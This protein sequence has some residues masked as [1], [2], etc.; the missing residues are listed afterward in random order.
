MNISKII[1][2]GP[3]SFIHI[4][5]NDKEI[6]LF[7]DEHIDYKKS[8]YDVLNFIKIIAD[9]TLEQKKCIDFFL[10]SPF[11]NIHTKQKV[12]YDDEIYNDPPL[13]TT[14]RNEF[15]VISNYHSKYDFFRIHYW[16]LSQFGIDIYISLIINIE[17]YIKVNP[18]YDT[19]TIYDFYCNNDESK[20]DKL[21]IQL[22]DKLNK[23]KSKP[24]YFFYDEEKKM[25]KII[26]K[27][28]NNIDD[29]FFNK[30]TL[31][32]YF[33]MRAS[34]ED[35]RFPVRLSILE[36][37]SIARIFRKKFKN[38]E[39]EE[40][41]TFGNKCDAQNINNVIYF[42]G[43]YHVLNIYSFLKSLKNECIIINYEY[44][45]NSSIQNNEI[46]FPLLNYFNLFDDSD[47][48]D[49]PLLEESCNEPELKRLF[50]H[51]IPRKQK[52]SD[53][54]VRTLDNTYYISYYDKVIKMTSEEYKN[55]T[56]KIVIPEDYNTNNTNKF[57]YLKYLKYKFKYLKLKIKD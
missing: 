37:Y 12:K 25:S 15:S 27:Q 53:S 2:T 57:T 4:K 36:T 38:R 8:P 3:I 18:I 35:G 52:K 22:I 29:T 13:L 17:E 47:D 55:Y 9:K 43:E 6:L 45:K 56:S 40:Y 23:S 5:L 30:E 26:H 34:E 20:H 7:G 14:L 50:D 11:I 46:I 41:G 19:S 21:F 31:L 51:F 49:D 48:P 32:T 44:Y 1:L 16:D 33:R 24:N 10:E 28:L 42:G 39:I 54:E